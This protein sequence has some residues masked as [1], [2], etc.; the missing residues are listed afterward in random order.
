MARTFLYARV[1]T[2]DQKTDNQLLE[3]RAVRFSIEPHRVIE[4]TV[5]GSTSATQR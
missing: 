5:S 3:A 1:S 4:E 2:I